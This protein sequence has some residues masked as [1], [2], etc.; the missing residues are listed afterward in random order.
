[1]TKQ[2]GLFIWFAAAFSPCLVLP[3]NEDAIDFLNEDTM[4][5][6]SGQKLKYYTDGHPKA[7]GLKISI[8]YPSHWAIKEGER[9]HVV[10]KFVGNP[11][12]GLVPICTLWIND[13]PEESR[14]LSEQDLVDTI[15][16]SEG[17]KSMVPQESLIRGVG[18]TKY[19]AQP[20]VWVIYFIRG[21][22]AGIK[23]HSFT[24]QHLL[25]YSGK[26]VSLQCSV[27]GLLG[28][29]RTVEAVFNEYLT[30]FRLMG[31]SIIL[32]NKWDDTV[33]GK[34]ITPESDV[35][36]PLW[37]LL[38]V[39]GFALLLA[40]ALIPSV[41]IRFFAVRHPLTKAWS[42]A[43]VTVLGFAMFVVREILEVSR[44]LLFLSI[45]ASY[46]ILRMGGGTTPGA[47]NQ[48][49]KT[50][51]SALNQAFDGSE[52]MDIEMYQEIDDSSMTDSEKTRRYGAVLGL[53]GTVT[54]REIVD[55][56]KRLIAKYHPDKVNHLGEEIQ[57][58][59]EK[60]SRDIN[61]AYAYLKQKFNI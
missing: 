46:R 24:L 3:Q 54:K 49:L 1:M 57:K 44:I 39:L 15:F 60:K 34:D 8:E 16:S 38:A 52:N 23:S 50:E 55:A 21:E 51:V 48:Q 29:N 53:H 45:W 7:K 32:Y 31:N 19:D 30:L 56:Y 6:L 47:T 36:Y 59:A 2:L 18:R 27:G 12:N 41:L 33:D 4:R 35:N 28:D 42:Y 22:R 14:L 25:I 43:I 58:Y 20:G 9:P 5:F 26:L 13:L 37:I 40:I 11:S 17:I 10:Q 61:K